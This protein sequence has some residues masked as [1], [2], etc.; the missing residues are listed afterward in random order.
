ML[1]C[2]VRLRFYAHLF[3]GVLRCF[4]R[5]F[6][7]IFPDLIFLRLYCVAVLY[8]WWFP[9]S[10]FCAFCV[11]LLYDIFFVVV[12]YGGKR[13]VVFAIFVIPTIPILALYLR[14]FSSLRGGFRY[15]CI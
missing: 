14:S 2:S 13:A 15:S 3:F 4:S 10:L 1:V 8:S 12:G 7:I 6:S 11:F 5:A 9:S